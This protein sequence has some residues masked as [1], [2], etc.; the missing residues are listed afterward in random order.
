MATHHPKYHS[1]P[2]VESPMDY[3]QHEKTYSGFLTGIKWTIIAL[4]VLIVILY[5]V[6]RP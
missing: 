5:F 6:I 3:A 1:E 2:I 4:A